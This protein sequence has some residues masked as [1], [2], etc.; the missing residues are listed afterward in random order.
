VYLCLG[1]SLGQS[2]AV[3]AVRM[4]RVMRSTMNPGDNVVLGLE[5]RRD[6]TSTDT[7]S[8]GADGGAARHL[9]AFGLVQSTTGASLDLSRFDFRPSF[10]RD[11]CRIETHLVARRAFSLEVPGVCD[12]RFK[13]GESIRTSVSCVFDRS[14]VSAMLGGVG[15]RLEDWTTD[16]DSQYVVALAVPAS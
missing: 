16:R 14:R 13:K 9:A 3:G 2:T 7:E 12:V 4:L 5:S 1:N 10:D 11:N 15:L 6:V 8:T